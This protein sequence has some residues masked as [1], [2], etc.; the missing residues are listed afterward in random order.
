[1]L[2][3]H[4]GIAIMKGNLTFTELLIGVE[5]IDRSVNVSGRET[6]QRARQWPA[7]ARM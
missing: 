7:W 6:F 1:M 3:Y 4:N 2:K 5:R